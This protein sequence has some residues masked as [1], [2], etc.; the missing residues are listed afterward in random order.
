MNKNEIEL[1]K[2]EFASELKDISESGMEELL[3]RARGFVKAKA[4]Q[5]KARQGQARQG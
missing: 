2:E 4:R 1:L 5:G 3:D